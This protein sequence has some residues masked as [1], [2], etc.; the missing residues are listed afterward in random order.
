MLNVNVNENKVRELNGRSIIVLDLEIQKSIVD[1][2]DWENTHLMR[3]SCLCMYT[4]IDQRYRVF[5]PRDV[6]AIRSMCIGAECVV[7]H[8]INR[9][10]LPIIF[11]L[12]ARERAHDIC[13]YDTLEEIWKSLDLP[14]DTFSDAH[15]GYGLD[16][17]CRHTLNV[18]KSGSG[19]FAPV[20]YQRGEFWKLIDYCLEDVRMAKMLFEH[21][22][23]H[24]MIQNNVNNYVNIKRTSI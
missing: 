8:N 13:T 1:E 19:A 18:S 15:K 16:R 21:M 20:L 24:A 14:L 22:L 3:I 9:F 4:Y 17:V 10:D 5:G 2:K 12:P 6:D 11:N 23:T 7:G